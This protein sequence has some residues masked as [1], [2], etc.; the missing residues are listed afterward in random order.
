MKVVPNTLIYLQK[1]HIFL[2]CLGIFLD[3]L[4]TSELNRNSFWK[5][6]KSFCLTGWAHEPDPHRQ[7]NRDPHQHDPTHQ[8]PCLCVTPVCQGISSPNPLLALHWP[9]ASHR[10]A[11]YPFA[12]STYRRYSSG[13]IV[14]VHATPTAS[15]HRATVQSP[16]IAAHLRRRR[17]RCVATMPWTAARLQDRAQHTSLPLLASRL[18]KAATRPPLSRLAHS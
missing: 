10:C 17:D 12:L 16:H 5:H 2:W 11:P 8:P 3:F 18:S 7:F 4:S 15:S 1:F 14:H 6:I 13:S 9:P